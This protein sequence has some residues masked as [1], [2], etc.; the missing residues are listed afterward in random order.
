MIRK[1]S[2]FSWTDI[3][4]QFDEMENEIKSLR[5]SLAKAQA[6][7]A[8]APAPAPVVAPAASRQEDSS[9][10]AQRLLRN[11]QRVSDETIA[12]ARS[13]ADKIVADA[14][15]SKPTACCKTRRPKARACRA[16]SIRS[17]PR[18]TIIAPASS[19]WWKIRATCST[20]KPSFSSKQSYP[21]TQS[22]ILFL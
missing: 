12:D 18:R 13:E 10:A 17:A 15:R 16:A 1:K 8:A 4:D 5:A 19:A 9:E 21:R 11:A 2:T 20:R 22:G 6:A 7:A 14:R 3:C